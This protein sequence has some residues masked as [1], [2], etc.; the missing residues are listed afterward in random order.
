[1]SR[2]FFIV[3]YDIADDKRRTKVAKTMLDFGD[4]VQYSVF[5]CQLNPRER[6][7]MDQR[8]KEKLHHGE[9]Q[10]L[11]VDA[12][13]VTGQTPQPAVDYLGK[14]YIVSPRSQII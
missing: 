11:V 1:M 10:V 8:L 5:C 9:D 3:S 13:A 4:R 7:Q 14:T 6:V 12:G 2:R